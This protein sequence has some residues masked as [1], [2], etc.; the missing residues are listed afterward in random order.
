MSTNFYWKFS[1]AVLSV[2][3]ATG[4][5]VPVMIDQTDPD[6]HIGKVFSRGQG[7]APG[8]IWAQSP[9]T[10]KEI[11][12]VHRDAFVV[13]DGDGNEHTGAGFLEMTATY[14]HDVS[15]VGEWFS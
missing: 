10:V 13:T 4:E 15:M 2:V 3:L 12:E 1:P 6:I 8:F 5:R 11:C 14:E 9:A 7:R